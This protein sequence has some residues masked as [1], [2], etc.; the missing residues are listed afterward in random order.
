[1]DQSDD[2]EIRA[3][4]ARDTRE[5]AALRRALFE[6]AIVSVSDPAGVILD[7]NE[8]F[9]ALS[10]Y[11]REELIGQPHAIVRSDRHPPEFFAQMWRRIQAG[12]VWRGEICNRAKDGD[13]YWVDS[14]IVPV[15]DATGA[16]SR[17]V[18]V[19][20]EV[21]RYKRAVEQ[22][23]ELSRRKSEVAEF[24]RVGGWAIHGR[25]LGMSWDAVMAS[26]LD[27][28]PGVEPTLDGFLAMFE[29]D[30]RAYLETALTLCLETG[31]IFDLEL[32]ARTQLGRRIWTRILGRPVIES[33]AVVGVTGVAQDVSEA[34]TRDDAAMRLKARF[35]A[36]LSNLP[37]IVTL[38]DR[39]G[40]IHYGNE[41][42]KAVVGRASVAGS[43]LPDLFPP[44]VAERFW[45]RDLETFETGAPQTT[46]ET[47][48]DPTH[49]ESTFL[50][51]RFLID[52]PI[53]DAKLLGVIA[54]DITEL[55][56]L[57]TALE[58]ARAEAEAA[59]AAKTAFL[60][61]MSHEIRTP[62]NG[63][64]GMIEALA[65]TDLDDNQR[66]KVDTLRESG[67]MLLRLLNDILDSSKIEAGRIELEETRFSPRALAESVCET[68]APKAEARG[69]AVEIED[70]GAGDVA[71]MGDPLRVRQIVHNLVS[72]AVKFTER[73][74]VR[75]GLFGDGDGNLVLR[76]SD[77]GVGMTPE[78]AARIFDRFS[79]AEASTSRRFGGTGLGLSIVKGLVEAMR[80]SVT[81]ESAPGVGSTFVVTL[82]LPRAAGAAPEPETAHRETPSLRRGLRALVADDTEIN[83]I[84]MSAFLDG[85]GVD[86]VLVD[87][88][89]AAAAQAREKT[90]DILLLD[91]MMPD[92][93]GAQTLAAIRA[94][95]AAAGRLAP[96]AVAVTGHASDD[97]IR[98]CLAAGFAAHL[99]KPVEPVA[100][101]SVI[102]ELTARPTVAAAE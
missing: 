79:Q 89:R 10:G 30:D 6:R 4:R 21:T 13:E 98:D 56:A 84:V 41:R 94:D 64:L 11:R 82:P 39:Q 77:D 35:E 62:M 31:D 23:R 91:L 19:R 100:L 60:A 49:G 32:P 101:A 75:L 24:A 102:A 2:S 51:S 28:R 44:D 87:G 17:Y 45:A 95:A 46:E 36:I 85:L 93:D 90:F 22:L 37:S 1:L 96:P 72:N 67:G 34:H 27:A 69:V 52:D 78:Q 71:R 53:E 81:V 73:G 40:T 66:S 80:G 14:T 18:A 9:C 92:L 38:Q 7:V 15:V 63:V 25:A 70:D 48:D 3:M 43:C 33:G 47:V 50:T 97:Q 68:H 74:A 54:T 58:K 16:I 83:R 8:R 12:G 26:I 20:Y 76:I 86:G 29:P 57:Q 88:G 99:G 65:A 59:T 55:K 61:T 5:S 42:F